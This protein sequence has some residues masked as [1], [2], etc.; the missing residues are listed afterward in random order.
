MTNRQKNYEFGY[1]EGFKGLP[2]RREFIAKYPGYYDG[3]D[4]GNCDR[5][6]LEEMIPIDIEHEASE[7]CLN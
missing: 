6:T 7:S 2:V 3:W 5:P 1:R 4:A